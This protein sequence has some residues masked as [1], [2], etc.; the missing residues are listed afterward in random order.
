MKDAATMRIFTA[1]PSPFLQHWQ[2][3]AHFFSRD[4]GLTCHALREFG[5]ESRVVMPRG[6]TTKEHPDIVRTTLAEMGDPDWWLQFSLDGVVFCSWADPKYTPIA[7]AIKN[8]G[9]KLILRC[10]SG[11]AYSQWQVNPFQAL[12]RNYLAARYRNKTPLAALV[13]SLVKTPA[14]Y[15]PALYERK[16]VEHMALAD[17]ILNETPEGVRLLKAL[18]C[19]YGRMETAAR[20][21]YVPH[22]VAGEMRYAESI[23][24][25]NQIIAVGN[26][27]HHAKNAPLLIR[28]LAGFLEQA[29]EYHAVIF[30]LGSELLKKYC[31]S[32]SDPLIQ[33]IQIRGR[34]ANSDLMP[35]YQ[36]SKIYFAP[37]RSE[38]FNI[39]G[40]EALSCGCS[41][42]GRSSI[43]SFQN[44]VSRNSG[45]LACRYS[46]DGMVEALAT[47]SMAW[48]GGLRNPARISSLW[49]NEVSRSA[50]AS[51]IL[52]ALRGPKGVI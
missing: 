33:R 14:F 4:M 37:S 26:W 23:P 29:L 1:I 36:R 43:F 21:L 15:I 11:G 27:E 34:V 28:S 52:M 5:V 24:K 39:A 38:S 10:D 51:A 7:K 3:D 2:P 17:V 18:L 50:V 40:A 49:Y 45:T 35:E 8:S 25:D 22:P 41:F 12:S 6:P 30:G 20:V 16:V 44:F 48:K 9:A 42:V 47:E 19:R 13:Y 31:S 32:L 46:V